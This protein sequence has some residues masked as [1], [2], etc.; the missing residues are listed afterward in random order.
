M[1]RTISYVFSCMEMLPYDFELQESQYQ[2]KYYEHPRKDVQWSKTIFLTR[3]W[4]HYL[5]PL[6]VLLHD[7]LDELLSHFCLI[8]Q[9]SHQIV[10]SD[11]TS[12]VIGVFAD[13]NLQAN[14]GDSFFLVQETEMMSS[15]SLRGEWFGEAHVGYIFSEYG[16]H[17]FFELEQ[18]AALS[19][20]IDF[21]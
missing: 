3:F 13:C 20:N 7:V 16:K 5:H 9:S 12:K 21:D 2:R 8:P 4:Y 6:C 14:F 11:C 10:S 17:S 18:V 19:L 15:I 1:D